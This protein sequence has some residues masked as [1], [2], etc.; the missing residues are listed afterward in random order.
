MGD[1]WGQ[2]RVS[3]SYSQALWVQ[4]WPF[5]DEDPSEENRCRMMDFSR[6]EASGFLR[7]HQASGDLR[8]DCNQQV[9]QTPSSRP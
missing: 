4:R 6:K 3:G 8:L 9:S 7:G 1:K 5:P 2:R